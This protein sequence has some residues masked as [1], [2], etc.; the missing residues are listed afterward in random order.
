MLSVCE[1]RFVFHIHTAI[2]HFRKIPPQRCIACGSFPPREDCFALQIYTSHLQFIGRFPSNY[3]K[4][5]ILVRGVV[6]LLHNHLTWVDSSVDPLISISC[7]SGVSFSLSQIIL[8]TSCVLRYENHNS[9]GCI[10]SA[11]MCV[12]SKI[13]TCGTSMPVYSRV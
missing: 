3:S 10:G 6:F 13:F 5:P 4:A 11:A 9:R 1:P 2:K 12:Y 7:R 8:A